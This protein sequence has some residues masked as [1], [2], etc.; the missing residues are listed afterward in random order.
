MMTAIRRAMSRVSRVRRR[1]SLTLGPESSTPSANRHSSTLPPTD[2][3]DDP[4]TGQPVKTLVHRST[5]PRH[6][7]ENRNP[8]RDRDQHADQHVDP[9]VQ[10]AINVPQHRTLH[11]R[12]VI[13]QGTG[14]VSRPLPNHLPGRV[15]AYVYYSIHADQTLIQIK[16]ASPSTSW[17]KVAKKYSGASA[18]SG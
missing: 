18:F 4:I 5:L 2:H 15:K 8:N 17:R 11:S 14:N 13:R 1:T 16:L 7:R 10:S 6:Q 9:F 3:H 12:K